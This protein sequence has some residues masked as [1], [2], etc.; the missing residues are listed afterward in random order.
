MFSV[1]A[2]RPVPKGDRVQCHPGLRRVA[3]SVA[4]QPTGHPRP[5]RNG[6]VLTDA[7]APL[8]CKL[9]MSRYTIALD[10]RK[11][12]GRR[13]GVGHYISSLIS[14]LARI[15]P[16]YGYVLLTNTRLDDSLVPSGFRPVVL[17]LGLT[18]GSWPAKLYAPFWMNTQLPGALHREGVDL[19]H[20]TNFFMPMRKT[21]P[22]VVTIH[23]AAFVRV[24]ETYDPVYRRYM[25]WQVGHSARTADR[26]ITGTE[27]AKKDIMDLFAVDRAKIAVAHNGTE[28]RCTAY[29]DA[30]YLAHTRSVLALPDRYILHVGVVE[31][32]KNIETLLRASVEPLQR[33]LIDAIV[34]VGREG[35]GAASVRRAACVLGIGDRVRFLGYVSQDQMVGVYHLARLLVFSSWFEGFGMPILEA[36]ACGTPVVASNTSSMPEVAGEAAI[37]F[38]PAD[39]T[40]LE[41][42][43]IEVLSEPELHSELRRRGLARAAKFTWSETAARHVEVYRQVLEY[44]DRLR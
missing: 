40:A 34:L 39:A 44:S 24:P 29:P 2:A 23:D 35:R 36:M 27:H 25:R 31:T 28:E 18:D 33:R 5:N 43:V 11:L 20:G 12:S 32:R 22:T 1:H 21:C 14:H 9:L 26:L 38:P 37:L 3:A 10:A 13:S 6:N 42:A 15:A 8:Y 19:Y 16:E 30:A 17:G 7:E 4:G 41:R